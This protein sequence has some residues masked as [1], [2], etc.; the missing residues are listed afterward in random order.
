M[1]IGGAIINAVAFSGSSYLF[2]SFKSTQADEEK[3]RHDLALERL[4]QAREEWSKKRTAFL[5]Y[6]NDKLR[7]E[8]HAKQTFTDIDRALQEYYIMTGSQVALPQELQT[9]NKPKLSDY[10]T[11]SEYQK[12]RE[13]L[14]IAVGLSVVGFVTYEITKD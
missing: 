10:Y 3:K 7:K 1:L 11:P 6:V 13:I 14:F 4:T 5:D 12:M 8:A 2:S 9:F